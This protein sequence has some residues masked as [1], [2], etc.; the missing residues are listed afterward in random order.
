MTLRYVHHRNPGV[1]VLF[2]ML[3]GGAW[4]GHTQE[5]N[6]PCTGCLR[7]Q[8]G[9]CVTDDSLCDSCKACQADGTCGA[10]K[11]NRCR[12]CPDGACHYKCKNGVLTISEESR[13]NRRSELSSLLDAKMRRFARRD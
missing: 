11:C 13:S 8:Q 3:V 4:S 10:S 1:S 7:C 6:P 2:P 9:T 12:D 5:C